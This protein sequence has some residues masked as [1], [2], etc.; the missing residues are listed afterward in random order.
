MKGFADLSDQARRVWAKSCAGALAG[1]GGRG[2][3]D[4]GPRAC[5]H[6]GLGCSCA[7]AGARA[8]GALGCLPGRLA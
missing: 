5:E 1:R 2:R 3:A 4:A 7:G 8:G 6:A